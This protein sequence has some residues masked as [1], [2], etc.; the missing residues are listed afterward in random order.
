[1][2]IK[3]LLEV[4]FLP[5]PHFLVQDLNTGIVDQHMGVQITMVASKFNSKCYEKG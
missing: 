2:Y 5:Y 4:L 3:I 1:M